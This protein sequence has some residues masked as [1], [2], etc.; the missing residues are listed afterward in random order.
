MAYQWGELQKAVHMRIP[1]AEQKMDDFRSERIDSVHKILKV[2]CI[3]LPD[4]G[5][6]LYRLFSML[7][8]AKAGSADMQRLG[9]PIDTMCTCSSIPL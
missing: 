4:Y 5:R 1:G 2:C 3:P 6:G 7:T 9:E 8:S